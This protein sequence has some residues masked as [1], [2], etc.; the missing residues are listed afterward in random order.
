MCLH[1]HKDLLPKVTLTTHAHPA[2]VP[3]EDGDFRSW[4]QKC[5]YKQH[6]EQR[7]WEVPALV[8]AG[9]GPEVSSSP[10]LSQAPRRAGHRK[11]RQQCTE[12]TWGG[13]WSWIRQKEQG[14]SVLCTGIF[15]QFRTG[16]E[17][18]SGDQNTA[19]GS[20]SSQHVNGF[21]QRYC[22]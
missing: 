2:K 22:N 16:S 9:P 12:Q 4:W 13:R 5:E 15:Q 14:T 17:L 1:I 19:D 20:L 3:S 8:S 11:V 21:W 10:A 7:R 6:G 18:V